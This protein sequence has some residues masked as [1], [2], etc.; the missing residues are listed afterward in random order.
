VKHG[1][2][3]TEGAGRITIRARRDGDRTVMTV[4]DNG[5]GFGDADAPGEEGVGLRNTRERLEQLYGSA[6]RLTL[7]EAEGG[8]LI[9]EIVLPFHTRDD[10][11]TAAVAP[12]IPD[13][14]P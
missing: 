14:V 9:A 5:P 2:S 7:R 8:G 4:Q 10:L 1:V 13:T 3:K 6:Q 11:R 12:R